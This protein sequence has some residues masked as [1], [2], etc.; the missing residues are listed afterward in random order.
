MPLLT[1]DPSGRTAMAAVAANEVAFYERGEIGHEPIRLEAQLLGMLNERLSM[2]ETSSDDISIIL[3][4]AL[5]ARDSEIFITVSAVSTGFAN[6]DHVHPDDHSTT[7]PC[8]RTAHQRPSRDN[9]TP[10]GLY[11]ARQEPTMWLPSASLRSDQSW[12][13]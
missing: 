11:S 13:Y 2:E 10:K 9:Q 6:A 5:I 8:A 1:H 7:S 4:I 3:V 12:R